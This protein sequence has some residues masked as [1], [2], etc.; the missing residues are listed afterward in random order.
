MY[1]RI[2]EGNANSHFTFTDLEYSIFFFR[3]GV[4]AHRIYVAQL[5]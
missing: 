1:I 5:T 2:N 3:S 4:K